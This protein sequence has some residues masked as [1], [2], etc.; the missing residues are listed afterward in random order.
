VMSEKQAKYL[1][2]VAREI[3]SALK[4]ERGELLSGAG[5]ALLS[6]AKKIEGKEFEAA[7]QFLT[8]SRSLLEQDKEI[9]LGKMLAEKKKGA[10]PR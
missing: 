10:Q 5:I 7:L 3:G 6:A 2:A 8:K 4:L 9:R 1:S